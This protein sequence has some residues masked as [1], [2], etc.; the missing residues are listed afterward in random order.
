MIAIYYDG[1]CMLCSREMNHY[2]RV[3]G[4]ENLSFIDITAEGF[5]A[6]AHG[7]DPFAVH[8]VMHAKTPD[9]KIVTRVDAF[10]AIWEALPNYKWLAKVA[11][12]P[13][14]KAGMEVGYTCFA[15]M[16]PFLPKNKAVASCDLSPYC[17]QDGNKKKN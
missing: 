14:V 10:I 16:R 6:A 1:L 5:D 4:A 8:K 9:G 13:L 3:R 12:N 15:K 2:R 7:L 17:D 11:K